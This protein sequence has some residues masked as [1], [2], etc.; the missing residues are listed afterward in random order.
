MITYYYYYC[1]HYLF[2]FLVIFQ[3]LSV[4]KYLFMALVEGLTT[5]LFYDSS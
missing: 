5:V 1:Y 3:S 4:L 2:L